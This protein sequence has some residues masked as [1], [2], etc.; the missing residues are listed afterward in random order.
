MVHLLEIPYPFFFSEGEERVY[1]S[2][3]QVQKYLV[4]NQVWL[5]NARTDG[6]RNVIITDEHLGT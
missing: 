6:M 1:L 5:C 4:Q 3:N 2:Q